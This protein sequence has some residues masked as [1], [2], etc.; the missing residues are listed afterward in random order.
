[1][2]DNIQI[3]QEVLAERGFVLIDGFHFNF[4]NTH[5]FAKF[6]NMKLRFKNESTEQVIIYS[7][8]KDGIT[9]VVAK[10]KEGEL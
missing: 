5:P 3:L 8:D 7:I 4:F 1:M 10:Y 2:F 9:E 6:P